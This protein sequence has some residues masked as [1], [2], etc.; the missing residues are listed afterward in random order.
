MRSGIPLGTSRGTLSAFAARIGDS[1]V[2][3]DDDLRYALRGN[4]Q[5]RNASPTQLHTPLRT[6]ALAACRA[7]VR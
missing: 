3:E 5:D 4:P 2:V 6:K 7:E 1:P